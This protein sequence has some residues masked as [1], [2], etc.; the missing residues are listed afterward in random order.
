MRFALLVALAVL[1][2]PDRTL[3]ATGT[4]AA[5]ML[6]HI[7]RFCDRHPEGCAAIYNR[8]HESAA[9]VVGLSSSTDQA[10]SEQEWDLFQWLRARTSPVDRGTL[11]AAD[12]KTP[13]R[14]S[15]PPNS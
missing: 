15:P 4:E 6:H 10:K 1:L 5:R 9:Y 2:A 13:W 11:T 7:S 8:A 12:L 14:G 3:Y